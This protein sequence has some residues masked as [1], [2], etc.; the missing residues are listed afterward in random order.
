MPEQPID[1]DLVRA[2]FPILS[3]KIRQKPL[4]Y[5]DNAASAQ[6]PQAVLDAITGLYSGYYANIHRGVHTLSQEGTEAYEQVRKKV[7]TF[8]GASDPDTVIFTRGTTEGLNLLSYSLG[9][10]LK[11]GDEILL[12]RMEHHSN[13]VPWQMACER[14]GAVLKVAEILPNGTLN[15]DHFQSQLSD[16]TKLVSMTWVSNTLGSIQPVKDCIA[17]IRALSPAVVILDAAQAA[18]HQPVAVETLDCDFLV[19]SAHKVVGPTGVGVLWGKKNALEALPPFHGGGDMIE[20]VTFEKTTYNV[21]P[22]RL[23]AGTPN[24]AGVIGFGAAID[25]L[26]GLGMENIEAREQ[27]LLASATDQL[28]SEIPDLRIFGTAPKKAAVISFLVGTAH[29][30]DLGVL[31]DQQGVAVRTGHHCT[32]PL[33]DFFDIPG[34]A[35]AS[36]AF[37]NNQTDIDIF[38]HALKRA[39]RMLS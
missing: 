10:S 22:F 12:T 34:T 5:L 19:F 38:V 20:R 32:Q 26:N 18:P 23:E 37:Y 31:L 28:L 14:T 4:V 16:K 21:L 6:K 9:Q 33:M 7:A 35:R 13:I 17:T 1:W 30:Y 2:D 29:P 36:F 15:L 24:I 8:I 25:Y 3:R 27:Q 11:P 39:T